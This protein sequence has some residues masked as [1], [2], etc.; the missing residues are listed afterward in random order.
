MLAGAG[1]VS[2]SGSTPPSR[3]AALRISAGQIHR[4]W[5]AWLAQNR[6]AAALALSAAAAVAVALLGV[7]LLSS[8]PPAPLE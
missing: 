4:R 6:G 2:L 7:A 1:R 3:P 5:R 8:A